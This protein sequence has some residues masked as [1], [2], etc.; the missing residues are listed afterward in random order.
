MI[1]RYS[2]MTNIHFCATSVYLLCVYHSL[3]LSFIFIVCAVLFYDTYSF[4]CHQC[5]FTLCM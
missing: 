1:V 3:L 5:V 2:F 4:L